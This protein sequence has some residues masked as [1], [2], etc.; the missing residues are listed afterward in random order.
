MSCTCPLWLADMCGVG[1]VRAA[2]QQVVFGQMAAPRSM[3]Q[4]PQQ[5][6]LYLP[7]GWHW[8]FTY[9]FCDVLGV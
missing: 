2:L 1:P 5:T 7:E 3:K 4:K 9:I 6:L 8:T